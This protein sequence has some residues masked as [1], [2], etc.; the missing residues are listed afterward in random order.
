MRGAFKV[1]KAYVPLPI[2]VAITKLDSLLQSER[3]DLV[4]ET[5]IQSNGCL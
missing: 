1:R 4:I 5:V 3:A 2:V